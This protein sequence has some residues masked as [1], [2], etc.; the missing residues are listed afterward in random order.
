MTGQAEGL[1][2]ITTELSEFLVW[3]GAAEEVV[4]AKAA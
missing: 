1:T 3:I 2:E 4:E